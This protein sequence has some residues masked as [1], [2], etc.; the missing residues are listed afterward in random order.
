VAVVSDYT[1]RKRPPEATRREVSSLPAFTSDN[2]QYSN[3]LFT[4]ARRSNALFAA[5]REWSA[6]AVYWWKGQL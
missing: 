3:P 6:I 1:A 5:V 4:L 2:K